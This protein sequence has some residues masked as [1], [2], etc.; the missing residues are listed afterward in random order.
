MHGE[1]KIAT[2]Q[3]KIHAHSFF[4]P[5]PPTPFDLYQTKSPKLIPTA[6]V[7]STRRKRSLKSRTRNKSPGREESRIQSNRKGN[8]SCR[9]EDRRRA[10]DSRSAEILNCS[11]AAMLA[12][13]ATA[14][15]WVSTPAS[16][17]TT[18]E[19]LLRPVD[20]LGQMADDDPRVL[21]VVAPPNAAA[22]AVADVVLAIIWIKG[23]QKKL[24]PFA[25]KPNQCDENRRQIGRREGD[26]EREARRNFYRLSLNLS[27]AV[28]A[29]L[30]ELPRR[31]RAEMW[32]WFSPRVGPRGGGGG[33]EE[34]R[35]G[36]SLEP[37]VMGEGMGGCWVC[38]SRAAR[39]VGLT[40]GGVP[41]G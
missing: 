6:A 13:L 38:R 33:E 24:P 31:A 25:R 7:T 10:R 4:F 8:S 3:C 18:P 34:E 11:S 9:F 41:L 29:V 32:N 5:K 22:A 1:R 30:G 15:T 21:A 19:R 14:C 23:R 28:D 16:H 20:T 39:R 40:R 37:K 26:T 27:P 36:C 17:R 35:P 2:E 12:A